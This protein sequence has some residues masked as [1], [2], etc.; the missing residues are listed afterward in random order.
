M[1]V[2]RKPRQYRPPSRA[3]LWS[4]GLRA[5]AETSAF[6]AALPLLASG[7]PGDGHDVLVLPGLLADD[8]ST[9]ALRH[10]LRR[11]GFRPHAWKLGPNLGPTRTIVD[12][13][14]RRLDEIHARTG[15]PVSLVGW[16]LGGILARQL[17]RMAPDKVRCVITLGS[18]F[19]LTIDD[20]P[21]TTHVGRVFHA[22]RP[23]HTDLLD[24]L[25]REEDRPPLEVPATAI[26]SKLDGIV[27][28]QACVDIDGPQRE[29]V[30]VTAS[31]LGM[32]VHPIVLAV[33]ID[34]LLQP[35]GAWQPY[36]VREHA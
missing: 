26:Y 7:R 35:V 23:W 10:V 18:P 17:A 6:F 13:L 4:D 12:G 8:G 1:T 16:S 2:T 19:R 21:D 36:G 31:H 34:R 33:I 14:L 3:L 15:E 20:D 22:L 24:H 32:G 29:S 30:E 11:R 28:W 9:T 27:P 5:G 25:G